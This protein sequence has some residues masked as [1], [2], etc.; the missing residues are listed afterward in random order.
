MDLK[1]ILFAL[2]VCFAT[3]CQPQK[4]NPPT[5]TA[6][7][8]L[9]DTSGPKIPQEPDFE[10]A[11][12]VHDLFKNESSDVVN[13]IGTEDFA[14]A[15]QK[16]DHY[17]SDP[18]LQLSP[19]QEASF[20]FM[21]IYALAGLVTQGKKTHGDLKKVLDACVGKEIITHH[22]EV[23]QGNLMPFNQVRVEQDVP[24]KVQI[25]CANNEGFNIHCFV[26]AEMKRE[27]PLEPQVGK[28]AYLAGKL[29]S[30]KL[31]EPTVVSWIADLELEE[32]FVKIL[33]DE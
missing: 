12:Q 22:Y 9:V 15:L 4:S 19:T 31:S 29:K 17:R 7:T 26:R 25:T 2:L 11:F 10:A 30:Y 14:L 8:S 13:T 28:R 1:I 27:F 5:L 24:G 33:E 23:T 20:R 6:D 18:N 21:Q 3:A 16:I 32:G